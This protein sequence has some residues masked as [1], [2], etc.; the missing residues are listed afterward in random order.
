[1]AISQSAYA[2]ATA[3]GRAGGSSQVACGSRKSIRGGSSPSNA[4]Y[5]ATVA[6][7]ARRA[8]PAGEDAGPPGPLMSL[9]VLGNPLRGP[10]DRPPRHRHRPAPP[11]LV[12]GLVDVTVITGKIAAAVHLQHKLAQRYSR[13]AHAG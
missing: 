9:R 5:P 1:M 7:A 8:R 2:V 11:A 4:S 3:C 12:G 10:G 6:R 13:P